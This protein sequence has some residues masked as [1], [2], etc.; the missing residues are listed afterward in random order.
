MDDFDELLDEI[1]A[2]EMK[3]ILDLVPNHTSDQ[4]PWFLESRSSRDNPKRDWYIWQ[5]AQDGQ[6]QIT[7]SAFLAAA[8]GS[9]TNNTD[10]IITM[11][12]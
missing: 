4:H 8:P 10:N 3:L 9:G 7:G 2:R 11:L 6:H 5:D 1:H 12:S